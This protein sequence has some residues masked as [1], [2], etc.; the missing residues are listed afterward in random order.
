M[1]GPTQ[2]I[3]RL[4]DRWIL[5]VTCRPMAYTQGIAFVS[6]LMRGIS[7]KV[8]YV[9]PQPDFA[10][11]SPGSP[12]VVSGSGSVI[13]ASGFTAGYSIKAGQY[14]SLV[15]NGVRYL[16]QVTTGAVADGTGS[17]TISIFPMLK[18]SL[19]A[20]NVLE[21]ASP[22][23]EGF[24]EGASQTWNVSL[25]RTVGLTFVIREAQ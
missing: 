22:K 2:R 24:L 10:I 15:K 19:V 3:A 17:A 9:V 18:V 12:I 21:F 25:A 16:H 4:G 20:G 14:F 8:T 11:G 1:G 23:I 5:R 7:E 6:A 13:G